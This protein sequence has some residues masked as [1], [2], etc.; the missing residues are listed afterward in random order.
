MPSHNSSDY[1]SDKVRS[2][3]DE[4]LSSI[5]PWKTNLHMQFRLFL[6]GR[7]RDGQPVQYRWK[8]YRSDIFKQNVDPSWQIGRFWTPQKQLRVPHCVRPHL[9]AA[10]KINSIGSHYFGY[11]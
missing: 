10:R 8:M 4:H 6:F 3:D 7:S 9:K 11:L 5:Q 1:V 2:T